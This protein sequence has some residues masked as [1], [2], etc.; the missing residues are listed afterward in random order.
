MLRTPWTGWPSISSRGLPAAIL[1]QRANE[2]YV[3]TRDSVLAHCR[4]R[5]VAEGVGDFPGA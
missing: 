3:W 4:Q 1:K 5:L 2:H